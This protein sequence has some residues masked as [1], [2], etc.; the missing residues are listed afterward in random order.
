MHS[1]AG[2]APPGGLS[3]TVIVPAFNEEP[4]LERAVTDY[5]RA[6]SGSAARYEFIVFNDCS[7]DRT[8]EIADRL[9]AANPRIR[10]VHNA[11]NR[12]LGYN[13]R[14]GVRLARHEFCMFLAGEGDVQAESVTRILSAAG[15]ADI[16]IPYIGNPEVRPRIR[17][18]LSAAFTS[19]VNA[20]FGLRVRYYNGCA[21]FRTADLRSVPMTTDSFAFQAEV[22]VRLLRQGR[23]Y[24]EL[25][26]LIR[27]TTGTESFRLRNL[28]GVARTLA[29]LFIE[30]RV[31]GRRA[32]RGR[33]ERTGRT[34]GPAPGAGAEGSGHGRVA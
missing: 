9:A 31:C 24:T 15:T 23:S 34:N 7:R 3:L 29:R 1:D 25:P 20:L 6:V 21:L 13:F 28:A 27:P 18:L 17:R 33:A 5:E 26:Y 2:Q 30:L 12:G 4:N 14:E 19:T 22:L 16:V 10:V 8:G 11:V 32:P